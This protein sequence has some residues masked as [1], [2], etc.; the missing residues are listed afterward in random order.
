MMLP[1]YAVWELV[2]IQMHSMMGWLYM[3]KLLKTV[4]MGNVCETFYT[5]MQDVA[6][7][8]ILGYVLWTNTSEAIT[9]GQL[10]YICWTWLP[11][12]NVF[13]WTAWSCLYVDYGYGEE[14]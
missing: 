3:L 8:W 13:S 5:C 9:S 14:L 7:Y 10:G 6:V 12:R 11:T 1:F 4:L 2:P